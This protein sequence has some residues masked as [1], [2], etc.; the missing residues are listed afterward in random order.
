MYVDNLVLTVD[1]VDEAIQYYQRS[2]QMFQDLNMNLREFAS[3][4][5]SL[6][7][8]MK[9]RTDCGS[10][11]ARKR[12]EWLENGTEHDTYATSLIPVVKENLQKLDRYLVAI[13]GELAKAE[14][15]YQVERIFWADF[16]QVIKQTNSEEKEREEAKM[17]VLTDD[18]YLDRL[19]DETCEEEVASSMEEPEPSVPSQPWELQKLKKTLEDLEDAAVRLPQRRIAY[20][21][22][23]KDCD[24]ECTFCNSISHYSDSC[25]RIKDGDERYRFVKKRGLCQYCLGSCNPYFACSREKND[26]FY[27][28]IMRKKESLRF[29]IPKDGGHHRAL[30]NIPNAKNLILERIREVKREMEEV[31]G[32]AAGG[33]VAKRD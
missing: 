33:S 27:C 10:V 3:N 5:I 13:E 21:S 7:Q 18:E 25:P 23:S 28:G 12:K 32:E 29:L 19:I 8:C 9:K 4:D 30:C 14:K 24:V 2:K 11:P 1:T 31:S 15:S 17:E 6:M 20:V 22:P 16:A 26:C